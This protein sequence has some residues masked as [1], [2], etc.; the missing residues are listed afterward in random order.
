MKTTKRQLTCWLFLALFL[1]LAACGT[2]QQPEPVSPQD[3]AHD[4]APVREDQEL[5]Q[6]H[7]TL[8]LPRHDDIPEAT[9]EITYEMLSPQAY[10]TLPEPSLY[11]VMSVEEAMQNRR[12]RRNFRD[13]ALSIDQVSQL[14]WAAYGITLPHRVGGGFRTTPS[15]GATFPLEVYI[16][17]G[18]IVGMYP[19]VFRYDSERHMLVRLH[20]G[21]IREELADAALGQRSVAQA[22]AVIFYSS[23]MQ[24]ITTHYGDRG[25]RYAYMELGH[26]AQNVYLQAEAL[27]LGTVAIG[28]FWD[29]RL[30]DIFRLEEG[31][32]P[33]YL[34][35]VGYFY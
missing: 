1:F 35:P 29:Y 7:A 31:E 21:D 4:E 23:V 9:R 12:S 10:Y 34:M 26:S 19:G 3:E 22:P 25:V 33:L 5:P 32:V 28:A 6:E 20:E 15:A 30:S 8:P 13:E 24:R 14:L 17:A 18:N 2:N 11:G 16:V 27:G